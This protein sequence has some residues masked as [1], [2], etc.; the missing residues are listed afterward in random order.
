MEKKNKKNEHEPFKTTNKGRS[1]K[2]TK[3][4]IDSMIEGNNKKEFMKT[5]KDKFGLNAKRADFILSLFFDRIVQLA[6]MAWDKDLP[7]KTIEVASI[8]NA[9]SI[10]KD[11]A[12]N[13]SDGIWV[14]KNSNGV[15]VQFLTE[16]YKLVPPLT[17]K[18][19]AFL[20]WVIDEDGIHLLEIKGSNGE[21]MIGVINNY[22]ESVILVKP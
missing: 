9:R 2:P 22:P 18:E 8:E 17:K 4:F 6:S 15:V 16:K 10:Q 11:E 12:V 3:S 14:K 5:V 21:Y 19:L 1:I 13:M 7:I 20:N